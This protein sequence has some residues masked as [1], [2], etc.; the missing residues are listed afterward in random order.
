[1][2][3]QR[4]DRSGGPRE[5]TLA[6]SP[7]SSLCHRR[8]SP[9]G[10]ARTPCSPFQVFPLLPHAL[11]ISCSPSLSSLFSSVL[12]IT[13]AASF[14]LSLSFILLLSPPPSLA[15]LSFSFSHS[16][17]L[18]FPLSLSHRVLLALVKAKQRLRRV[19][20][21]AH[22]GHLAYLSLRI[23]RSSRAKGRISQRDDGGM[24]EASRRWKDRAWKMAEREG[25][26]GQSAREMRRGWQ[27]GRRMRPRLR[28]RAPMKS[29]REGETIPPCDGQRG[30]YTDR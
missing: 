17:F 13:L 20:A 30:A 5:W 23:A 9:R 22:G 15:N 3:L 2:Y 28:Q 19:E 21:P 29:E 14:S 16:F 7:S 24:R 18:P 6:H 4:P 11:F 12:R 10:T 26:R 1:M 8:A 27:G 25:W